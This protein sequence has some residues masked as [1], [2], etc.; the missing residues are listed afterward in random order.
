MTKQQSDFI[1]FIDLFII[2]ECSMLNKRQ[3]NR[4]DIIFRNIRSCNKPFGGCHMLLVGDFFQ[5]PPTS[6]QTLYLNL[7]HIKKKK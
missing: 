4:I 1:K 3:L 2:D 6:G 7:S 5:L